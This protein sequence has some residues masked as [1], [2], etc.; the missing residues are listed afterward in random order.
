MRPSRAER[1]LGRAR[2]PGQVGYLKRVIVTPAVYPRLIDQGRRLALGL[3]LGLVEA[4]RLALG[5]GLGL[6]QA[7]RLAGRRRQSVS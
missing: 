4:R 6:V 2:E 7:R 1:S 3:G 5:L